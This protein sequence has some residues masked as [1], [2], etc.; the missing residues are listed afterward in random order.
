MV[1]VIGDI[2]YDRGRRIRCRVG[3]AERVWVA[4]TQ[5]EVYRLASV[6][7]ADVAAHRT[8]SKVWGDES[9]RSMAAATNPVDWV[10]PQPGLPAL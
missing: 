1:L 8:M 5:P 3:L 7:L 10:W 2:E 6:A 4:A 9:G